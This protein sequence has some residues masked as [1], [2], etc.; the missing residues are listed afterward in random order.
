MTPPWSLIDIAEV[1]PAL[2][3][4]D[5]PANAFRIDGTRGV[6]VP[7]KRLKDALTALGLGD[8]PVYSRATSRWDTQMVALGKPSEH[9][10][11]LINAHAS[12]SVEWLHYLQC[13]AN[14]FGKMPLP[15]RVILHHH[16]TLSHQPIA[17]GDIHIFFGESVAWGS[18]E[19]LHGRNACYT[20]NNLWIGE[21]GPEHQRCRDLIPRLLSP[22]L[23][24]IAPHCFPPNVQINSNPYNGL[25]DM[26]AK[27]ARIACRNIVFHEG[28]THGFN[29]PNDGCLHIVAYGRHDPWTSS[30]HITVPSCFGIPLT[31]AMQ[32]GLLVSPTKTNPQNKDGIMECSGDNNL[33]LCI[34]MNLLGNGWNSTATAVLDAC[35]AEWMRK[36]ADRSNEPCM[37]SQLRDDEREIGRAQYIMQAKQAPSYKE[38]DY[39]AEDLDRIAERPYTASVWYAWPTIT[40]FTKPIIRP[41]SN[42][43]ARA[44]PVYGPFRITLDLND[45]VYATIF[46]GHLENYNMQWVSNG[47]PCF[48]NL[49]DSIQDLYAERRYGHLLDV[50]VAFLVKGSHPVFELSTKGST[51]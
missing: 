16:P 3:A 49:S 46:V 48:G 47:R 19:W 24:R 33:T 14:W 31:D 45:R 5:I 44:W 35:L 34:L 18:T 6:L 10:G 29:P 26:L 1:T 38:E 30:S 39:R 50:V 42:N 41:I 36:F 25:R 32:K 43:N 40:V 21:L 7:T 11:A 12:T 2:A 13:A 27:W 37:L 8:T 4:T 15:C 17:D 9:A 28:S 20:R 23:P 51:S 22:L